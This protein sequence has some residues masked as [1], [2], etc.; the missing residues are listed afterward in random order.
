LFVLIQHNLVRFEEETEGRP[1]K[2]REVVFYSFD[3]VAATARL[4]FPRMVLWA[5]KNHGGEAEFVISHLLRNGKASL[6]HIIEASRSSAG[7]DQG[8]FVSRAYS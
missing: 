8:A 3:L 1:P 6:K 5:R 4:R 7:G 2:A